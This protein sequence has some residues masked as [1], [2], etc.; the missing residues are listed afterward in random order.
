V[1]VG[2]VLLFVHIRLGGDTLRIHRNRNCRTIGDEDMSPQEKA[3][4]LIDKYINLTDGWVYGIKNWEHKKQCA[5][6]CVDEIMH[7]I[8]WHEFET[9]NEELNYWNQVKEE[10]QK[11]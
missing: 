8:D 9:P 3:K 4:E 6:I 11:L 1:V 5:L 7:V 10:I 2:I